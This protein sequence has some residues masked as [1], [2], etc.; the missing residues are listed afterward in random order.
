MFMALVAGWIEAKRPLP[1]KLDSYIL[2]GI[3]CSA[4]IK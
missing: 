3:L 4:A 2:Q 1:S